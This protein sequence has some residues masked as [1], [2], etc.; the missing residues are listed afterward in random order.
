MIY[1]QLLSSYRQGG[2]GRGGEGRGSV[3]GRHTVHCWRWLHC[4][5][6]LR[7]PLCEER[8]VNTSHFSLSKRQ[9]IFPTFIRIFFFRS[10]FNL[11]HGHGQLKDIN[12][13]PHPQVQCSVTRHFSGKQQACQ[14]PSL[15][16]GACSVKELGWSGYVVG[17]VR[18][19]HTVTA[20]S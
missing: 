7:L 19:S 16:P 14:P 11:E 15:S 5:L 12:M 3:P 6:S 9:G 20:L 8:S 4:V 2:W 1:H 17:Q 18:Q 13:S 10:N